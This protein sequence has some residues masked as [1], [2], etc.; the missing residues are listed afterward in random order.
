MRGINIKHL[1]DPIDNLFI[2]AKD[3]PGIMTTGRYIMLS[4]YCFSSA[5]KIVT[6]SGSA[7]FIIYIVMTIIMIV[8]NELFLGSHTKAV[9]AFQR[10]TLFTHYSIILHISQG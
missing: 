7:M 4:F 6:I 10:E 2:A 3:I 1:V 5:L 8:I 9:H